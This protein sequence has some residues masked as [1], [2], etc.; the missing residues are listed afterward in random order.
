MSNGQNGKCSPFSVF[1]LMNMRI[2]AF[3]TEC[4]KYWVGGGADGL[5]SAQCDLQKL[6]NGFS[7]YFLRLSLAHL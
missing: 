7:C 3:M 2:Q 4:A 1:A 6:K 5:F